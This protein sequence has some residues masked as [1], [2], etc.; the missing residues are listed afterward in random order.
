MSGFFVWAY[1]SVRIL[2][3]AFFVWGPSFQDLS[4]HLPSPHRIPCNIHMKSARSNISTNIYTHTKNPHTEKSSRGNICMLKIPTRKFSRQRF[5][6]QANAYQNSIF[7]RY[8]L[9]LVT[10]NNSCIIKDLNIP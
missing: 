9:G 3:R 6:T 10:L 4:G 5:T 7:R 8:T 1:M 2:L